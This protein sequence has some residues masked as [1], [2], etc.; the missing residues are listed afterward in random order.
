LVSLRKKL[1]ALLE[2]AEPDLLPAGKQ[3][4]V[5]A[6]SLHPPELVMLKRGST[7]TTTVSITVTDGYHIL[8]DAGEEKSLIPLRI[9]LASDESITI[10]ELIYPESESLTFPGSKNALGV[11]S[12]NVETTVTL[13]ASSAAKTG[14]R[15][16]EGQVIYQSCSKNTCFPPDSLRLSISVEIIESDE[17]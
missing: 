2:S 1:S 7:A 12:G 4:A 11:F 9:D 15:S 8:A 13:S 5:P 10:S 3:A 17:D 6:I 14:Q 16:L